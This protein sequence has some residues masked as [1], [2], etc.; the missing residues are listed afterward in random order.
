MSRI[1]VIG[2]GVVGLCSAY[3]L[4]QRGADV[5]VLVAR[6]GA[7]GASLVNAGW[8]TPSLATPV[9][10]PGLIR[11]SM[12]WMLKSD[13]PLYIHPRSAPSMAN[14][15]ADFWKHCNERDF[16]AGLA[17]TAEFGRPTMTLYEVMTVAGVEFKMHRDGVLHAYKNPAAMEH[18]RQAL[19]GLNAF[20][21]TMPDPMD[22]NAVREFEP[23]LGPAVNAG[24]W[25]RQE[26]SVHPESL[27]D[28]LRA[29]LIKRRV[30]FRTSHQVTGFTRGGCG[31]SAVQTN[32]GSIE[33]DGAVICAG[34]WSSELTAMAG[35][36]LPLQGGKGYSLDYSPPPVD[37]K[38]P[39]YLHEA[40]VAV[41]PFNGAVRLA[42]TMEFSGINEVVRRP[43]VEAISRTASTM[44]SGWPSNPTAASKIGSGLRPMTPDGIPVI[45]LLAGYCNLAV[46]TGHAMLGVT[47][48][49]ATGNAIAEML[50]NG[51]VPNAVKPFSPAR[52]AK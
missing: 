48:G 44:L 9:P 20:G 23:A 12:K 31:I 42:G 30:D 27:I 11:T 33:C 24:Y 28:G 46:A 47:L 15:L 34:V 17:A 6:E 35:V 2:G 40:R 10:A 7:H 19:A 36:K 18:D 13:S 37:V 14:W 32:R 45:G 52:F 26:R 21:Y 29:W 5:T 16:R 25:I 50:V 43:R 39:I 49:P 38:H 3:F 41:T 22:G 4:H 1:V 8:I 51:R